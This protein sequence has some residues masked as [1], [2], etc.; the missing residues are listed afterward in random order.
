VGRHMG[1]RRNRLILCAV[2]LAGLG[3]TPGAAQAQ[4]S[5]TVAIWTDFTGGQITVDGQT[6][7]SPQTFSW[8]PGSSHT[9]GTPS[10]QIVSPTKRYLFQSWSDGG[11]QTHTVVAQSTTSNYTAFFRR[12]PDGIEVTLTCPTTITPGGMLN[13]SLTLRNKSLVVPVTIAKSAVAAH[14]GNLDI[15]GPFVIPLARTLAPGE[16]VTIPNYLSVPFPNAPRG[17]IASLGLTVMDNTIGGDHTSGG[18]CAIEVE[19]PP[20]D[21]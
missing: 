3:L 16:T 15:V 7:T 17:I 21:P 1:S 2:A 8:A 10:P 20:T 4:T 5:I 18:G 9:L 6:Y 11:P 14:L 13:V 19:Y 12:D